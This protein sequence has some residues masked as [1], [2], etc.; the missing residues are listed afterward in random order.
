MKGQQELRFEYLS[1]VGRGGVGGGST[2]GERAAGGVR[3]HEK[4]MAQFG[5]YTHLLCNPK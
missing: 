3:V 5:A 4:Y 1:G 2:R